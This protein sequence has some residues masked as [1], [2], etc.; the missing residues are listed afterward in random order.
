MTQMPSHALNEIVDG[1]GVAV[2]R[3][4]LSGRIVQ[5]NQAL[6][7]ILGAHS[8]EELRANTPRVRFVE[9]ARQEQ[10]IRALH[11]QEKFSPEEIVTKRL[12]GTPLRLGVRARAVVDEGELAFIDAVVEDL[13]DRA[14]S[15]ERRTL[16]HVLLDALTQMQNRFIS[17]AD[18]GEI[19]DGLLEEL[20]DFTGAEY[21]FIAQKLHA[22]DHD[23]LRTWAMSDISWNEQTKKLF[24]KHGPRGMEFHNL[25]TLFG[26]VAVGEGALLTNDPRNDPRAAG[27]PEGHPPLDSFLGVPILKGEQVLGIVALANRPGGF[28]PWMV[29]YL[30]PLTATVG[31]LIEAVVSDR[32]RRSAQQRERSLEELFRTVVERA[33]DAVVAFRDDGAIVAAN[34]AVGKVV[35]RSVDEIVGTS[36]RDYL[37]PDRRDDYMRLGAVALRSGAAMEASVVT[38]Q[39]EE[40]PVEVTV[41]RANL[42]DAPITTLIFRDIAERKAFEQALLDA[43]NAAERA[44]RAK[45]EL[46]AGMSHELRTP[47]NSVIGLSAI[48]QREIYGPL[49]PKQAEYAGQIEASGRHLLEIIG[50]ILDLSKIEAGKIEP[51]L[52]EIEASV[53]V[54][55]A[56]AVIRELAVGKALSLKVDVPTTLPKIVADQR[57]SKQL[58]INLLANAVKFTEMSGSIGVRARHVDDN[59]AIE[60][61]DTGIGIPPEF[62]DKIFEAFE[63][64]DSSLSKKHEGTGLGLALSQ[65]LALLQGG[66]LAVKS[67]L[68]EGSVFTVTFPCV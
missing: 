25:D 57:R 40:R 34:G 60:V 14:A 36:L 48:L 2:C 64:V 43:R 15:D 5:C 32:E 53:V 20:L 47:L 4:T 29:D 39:G 7:D 46:L 18:V 63:Q 35:G 10:L 61:W 1:L 56:V 38:A 26:R 24:A 68:G 52:A 11:A 59:I 33:A 54:N 30:A 41:V 23:F 6:L 67:T 13:S 31:S 45:N 55:E 3:T 22:D 9:P 37:P 21:G 42:D 27:R 51:E 49:T 66:S 50:D 44:V 8:I 58:L 62:L 12:D 65:R 28:D 19:F 16:S 17:G